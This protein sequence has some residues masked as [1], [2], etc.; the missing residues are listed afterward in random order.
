MPRPR[1]IRLN[2]KLFKSKDPLAVSVKDV[3]AVASHDPLN[4]DLL[5][6]PRSKRKKFVINY[7]EE[8][9]SED[10]F[11]PE[12]TVVKIARRKNGMKFKTGEK[13]VLNSC[14]TS[15]S[16]EKS[17]KI[18][19]TESVVE[20]VK[21]RNRKSEPQPTPEFVDVEAF[22]SESLYTNEMDERDTPSEIFIRES[23]SIPVLSIPAL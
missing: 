10:D 15:E 17:M 14:V 4:Q 23:Y 21:G 9:A 1:N 8:N 13:I 7:S 16:D 18:T 2:P 3:E 12:I 5:E 22:E 11:T 19:D 20:E 6:I